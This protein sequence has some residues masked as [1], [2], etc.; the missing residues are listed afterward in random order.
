MDR[1]AAR[2][3]RVVSKAETIRRLRLGD[4]QR[5]L[6]ARYGVTLPDDDAGRDDLYEMLLTI[7]LGEGHDRKMK[8]AI[9]VW[10]P[11][12]SADE[13][14]NVIDSVNRTPDYLRKTTARKMGEKLNLQ[15]WERETLGLRTIAPVDMTPEQLGAQRKTK[16]RARKW[17]ARRAAR[18]QPREVYLAANSI[19]R[20]KP[21]TVKGVSRATWYRRQ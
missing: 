17:R 10:A 9:E 13:A 15:N 7:S 3:W 16:D 14:R 6:R 4:L 2:W 18:K 21:W 8:N 1:L 11:W 5:V 19:S 12:M 20:Q